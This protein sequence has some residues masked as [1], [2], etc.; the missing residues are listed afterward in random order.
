MTAKLTHADVSGDGKS[1]AAHPLWPLTAAR[2][3]G[4]AVAPRVPSA[5]IRVTKSHW[6]I[7]EEKSSAKTAPGGGGGGGGGGAPVASNANIPRDPHPLP[8]A[9]ICVTGPVG[10]P[11]LQ[12]TRF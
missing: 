4:G 8:G 2:A 9:A 11:L 1:T 10:C 7:P 5:V 6:A 12:A 3:L